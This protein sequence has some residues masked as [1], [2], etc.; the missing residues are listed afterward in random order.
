M[1]NKNIKNQ[2]VMIEVKQKGRP[3][4]PNSPRQLRLQEQELKK[5]ADVQDVL[6]MGI[7]SDMMTQKQSEANQAYLDWLKQKGISD[8]EDTAKELKN[9][10]DDF[11]NKQ[12]LLEV[13]MS[14]AQFD[15]EQVYETLAK[16]ILKTMT[17]NKVEQEVTK[18]SDSVKKG[19]ME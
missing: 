3:V 18:P 13:K 1:K 17:I 16:S 8:A 2:P 4:N 11:K 14:K 19:T 9:K 12:E 15:F 7:T 6:R 10:Q 5:Q